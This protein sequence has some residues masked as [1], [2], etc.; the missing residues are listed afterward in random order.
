MSDVIELVEIY[1]VEFRR[2][3]HRN[4]RVL[5]YWNYSFSPNLTQSK[6]DRIVEK[7]KSKKRINASNNPDHLVIWQYS[8]KPLII[9]NLLN[10][11]IYTTKWTLEHF[12]ERYCMQQA[13]ILLQIL[14]EHGYASYRRKSITINPDRMGHNKFE[15]EI[16][17][18]SL[19]LLMGDE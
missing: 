9:L 18:K 11:K 10:R 4:P 15:R 13:A 2:E 7:I 5:I 6:I 17:M 1:P 8:G 16:F 14:K 3:K 19:K 12:G